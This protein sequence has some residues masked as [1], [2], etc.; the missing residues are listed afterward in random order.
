MERE[1]QEL[2]RRLFDKRRRDGTACVLLWGQPGGGKSHLARQYVHKNRDKFEGGIF[3]IPSK[4]KEER[5]Q[6]FWNIHQKV[7]TRAQPELCAK[8]D[9]REY[10]QIVKTWFETRHDWLI[11]FDGVTLDQ[12]EDATEFQKLVPDSRN[13]SIIYISRAKSLESKQRLLRPSAIRVASLKE[14]DARKLLF[15]ALHIKHPTEADRRKGT[16]LVKKVGGL[17]LAI[18]AISH[19]IADTHEPLAKFNIKSYSA[20]P[21]MGGTYNKILDDLQRL[22]HME[23]WNLISILCFFGQHIPVEMIHL[24][25]KSLSHDHVEVKSSVDGGNPDINTTFGILMRYALIERNEPEDPNSP[26]SSRDSLVE[27]EPIDVLK[28]HSVVQN[29]CCDSL[30]AMKTLPTWLGYAVRLFGYSFHQADAKIKMKPAQGRVSDYREYLTHGERLREHCERYKSSTQPLEDVQRYLEP[31]LNTIDEEIRYRE[32][33]SSQESLPRGVFQISIFDRTSSSSESNH[34]SE[35]RTPNHRPSPLPLP[36]ENMYSFPLD[37]PMLDSPNSLGTMTPPHSGGLRIIGSPRFPPYVNDDGYESDREGMNTSQPMRKIPS[38]NTAKPDQPTPRLQEEHSRSRA[39]TGDS[40]KSGWQIVPST[41]KIKK[42]R[43]RRDLGSFR[44]TPARAEVNRK[45]A[46][47]SLARVT[48]ETS[49]RRP[50][51]DAFSSLSDIQKRSPPPTR[52]TSVGSFWKRISSSSASDNAQPTWAGIA[53]GQKR[54]VEHT[55]QPPSIPNQPSAAAAIL[56][57]GRSRENLRPRTGN[58]AHSPLASQYIPRADSI[59][60]T[61]QSLHNEDSYATY[62][63][64]PPLGPNPNPLPYYENIPPPTK[65][66]LPSEFAQPQPS[67]SPQSLLPQ[68]PTSAYPTPPS[69]LPS[70]SPNS[71]AYQTYSPPYPSMPT[72]YTSQPM[73]RHGSRQS[74]ESVAETEPP[75]YMPTGLSPQGSYYEPP[76]SPRDRLPDGRP[77]RKSPRQDQALPVH[78]EHDPSSSTSTR[79]TIPTPPSP[80]QAAGLTTTPRAPPH[81]TPLQ[82]RRTIASLILPPT[83]TPRL[84]ICRAP[85]PDQA[86]R[87]TIQR[88]GWGLCAS[89]GIYSLETMRL[90]V[91]RRRDGGRW[92]MSSGLGSGMQNWRS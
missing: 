65:R 52:D 46:A 69:R 5:W 64:P 44:P 12:D 90:L 66:R 56:E 41:R 35:I 43:T 4:S 39:T 45:S 81:T 91:S 19:R 92:S 63:A 13:S 49:Q 80:A 17:P 27:P 7:V 84:T 50:S 16:E 25:L 78:Y 76:A 14:D 62:P 86:S 58:T 40:S 87:S 11:V 29:F 48:E 10:V 71:P 85:P 75:R 24:G 28:I 72:G 8:K 77:L 89:M 2:D 70:Q 82:A 22:G 23:A 73:S 15:K 51:A 83:P 3:W 38:D 18:D 42:T 30:Q 20:D 68:Q 31:I 36:H 1:Y 47:G 88:P 6:A 67:N 21:K 54:P 59:P 79:P 9:G 37:K 33:G 26:S 60:D 32:P 34:S 61:H 74:H 55:P 57:R 53:A